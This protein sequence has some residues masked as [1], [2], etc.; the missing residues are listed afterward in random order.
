MSILQLQHRFKKYFFDIL[1]LISSYLLKIQIIGQFFNII[2]NGWIINMLERGPNCCTTITKIILG[3]RSYSITDADGK[4][5]ER[6]GLKWF[7]VGWLFFHILEIWR[8]FLGVRKIKFIC[9][10]RLGVP[11][12]WDFCFA[13]FALDLAVKKYFCLSIYYLML[14]EQFFWIFQPLK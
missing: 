3:D 10:M 13:V 11:C 4:C 14:I 2:A 7:M 9:L 12:T 1:W 8:L 5:A 6:F